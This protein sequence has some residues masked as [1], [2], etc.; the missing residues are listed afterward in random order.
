MSAT[1]APSWLET[2]PYLRPVAELCTLAERACAES[3]G[4]PAAAPGFEDYREEFLSGI[5]LLRSGLGLVNLEPAGAA[6]AA[7]VRRLASEAPA[8]DVR[9]EAGELDSFLR[10]E[11]SSARRIPGWLL[12]DD[13]WTPPAPGLLRFAGWTAAAWHLRQA[14]DAFA[15]WRD[16]EKWMRR[17]CPAC[18][19]APA[20][21]Q[22]TEADLARV[23]WLCCGRCRSRWQYGR[24]KCAFCEADSQRLSVLAV[25]GEGGLRIDWCESC[26]GYLKTYAGQGNESLMLSDWS[27]LHLDLAARARGLVRMAASLFE[28]P[29]AT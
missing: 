23:R 1:T 5:P 17:W 13:E 25:E 20:M 16:E 28:L 8:A 19:S 7:I 29:R 11:P 10:G 4:P 12:D 21:G 26:R 18:G 3:A 24:T 15:R 2:H 9:G 14:V 27:S 22:L 6:A